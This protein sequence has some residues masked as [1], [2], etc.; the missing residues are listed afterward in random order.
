[1]HFKSLF[2]CL[3]LTANYAIA[4]NSITA[5][6]DSLLSSQVSESG[7][8]LSVGV[9]HQDS[10]IYTSQLGLANL[11][12]NTPISEDSKFPIASITKQ[13]TAA[14]IGVLEQKGALS[15]NDNVREYIPE[16]PDY[17]SKIQI[18]H[19]LNHTSGLRNHNVLL[20]LQGFDYTHQG[21]TN[22]SIES[23]IFRQ[24][25]VNNVPGEK[26]LY[27]NSNYVLLAL[28]VE[29]V[30]GKPIVQFAEEEIFEPLGLENTSFRKSLFEVF[31]NPVDTY[32]QQDGSYQQHT[33]ANLCIGAGGVITTVSDL[34]KWSTIYWQND[35]PKQWLATFLSTQD[36]LN[37]GTL[38]N[39]GRGVFLDNYVNLQTIRHGGRGW[40]SRTI[41]LVVP[42]EQISVVAFANSAETNVSGIAYSI[43]DILFPENIAPESQSQYVEYEA[44]NLS[45][46]VG[47]YQE[48]NS[49]L[50]MK[51]FVE[52]DT[53]KAK[54][55][56]GRFA[57]PLQRIGENTF[58]RIDNASVRH[59]FF[60][61]DNRKWDMT[62]DF[63]GAM[64]YFERANLA[65]PNS[66][67]PEEF[68]GNYH[69][70]ELNVTYH[71]TEENDRLVLNYPNNP[72]IILQPRRE[73]E[74][75][76]NRR[77]RYTFERNAEGKVNKLYV[78]A[79]GTVKN[80]VFVKTINKVE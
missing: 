54:A 9:L 77:T 58:Q 50:L 16:L 79:E 71:F 11:E 10:M 18:K 75:G 15:V 49:D 55:S 66:V 7:P 19:L 69:S 17:G 78:A 26:M 61:D 53:L 46:I 35:H 52:N 65:N 41:L 80:I 32:F 67:N 20:D 23:L 60:A 24:K 39:Y 48:L 40:A 43:L 12:Y 14:C 21:Y 62:V 3:Y 44:G 59:T 4:Q 28:I 37:D 8:G 68:A 38:L 13:F 64:F 45:D 31:K 47:D 70:E 73:D 1:M 51:I 33:S 6:I 57:V 27:G 5:K 29:R 56:M 2:L 74:F 25:D 34:L 42:E 76:S 36:T 72:D 63:G 22:E 30:S